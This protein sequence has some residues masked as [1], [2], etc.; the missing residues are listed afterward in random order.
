VLQNL[1][2]LLT[3]A[4]FVGVLAAAAVFFWQ[5]IHGRV[6]LRKLRRRKLP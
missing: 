3:S 1:A 5:L 6:S 4:K 2:A